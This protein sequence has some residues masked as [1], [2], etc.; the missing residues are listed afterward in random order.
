MV[1]FVLFSL[2]LGTID[3]DKTCLLENLIE[4]LVD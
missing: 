2:R 1:G 3:T 4:Q